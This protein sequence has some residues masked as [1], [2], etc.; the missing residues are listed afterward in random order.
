VS[1][2][3]QKKVVASTFISPRMSDK[4]I[5]SHRSQKEQET[6]AKKKQMALLA[7]QQA[8]LKA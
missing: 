3:K 4:S 8:Q 1:Q 6:E 7:I 5:K 2:D